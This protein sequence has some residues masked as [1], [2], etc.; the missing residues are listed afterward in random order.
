MSVPTKTFCED[1]KALLAQVRKSPWTNRKLIAAVVS[2]IAASATA[3]GYFQHQ[4]AIAQDAVVSIQSDILGNYVSEQEFQQGQLSQDA[5]VRANMDNV[6]CAL[7]KLE[8]KLERNTVILYRIAGKLGIQ[9][10]TS[11]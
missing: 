6:N 7:G 1:H 11:E 3:V 5:L 9:E 4:A 10:T 8:T 2:F